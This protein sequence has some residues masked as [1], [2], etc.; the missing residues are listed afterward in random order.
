[1]SRRCGLFGVHLWCCLAFACGVNAATR[2]ALVSTCGGDAA[3][4]V[5]ALAEAKLSIEPGVILV[6]RAQ[7]E[8]ILQEQNLWRCGLG[9]AEQAAAAGKLLGVELFAALETIPGSE[10]ALGLVTF[11]ASSG[12]RLSDAVLPAGGVDN[13]VE[14]IVAGVRAGC[15][16]RRR[17]PAQLRTVC[18]MSVRNAEL[19]R[20]LDSFCDATARLLERRLLG[21]EEVTVLERQRLEQINR[22]RA[23]PTGA[24]PT[25]LLA[26]LRLVEIEFARGP[27]GKGLAATGFL[28]DAAD[29]VLGQVQAQSEGENAVELAEGLAAGIAR[30]LKAAPAVGVMDRAREAERFLREARFLYEHGDRVGHLRALETVAALDPHNAT[31]R[32]LLARALLNSAHGA[33]GTSDEQ[34]R[35]CSEQPRL[36][37]CPL[38]A[39]VASR[40]SRLAD[41]RHPKHQDPAQQHPPAGR[42]GHCGGERCGIEPRDR[43]RSRSQQSQPA[44]LGSAGCS[45]VV[46]EQ[47]TIAEAT[48]LMEHKIRVER[49]LWA[50][51]PQ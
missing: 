10:Q 15:E 35:R 21:S 27:G 8:R 49:E 44:C 17:A 46:S 9:D 7:V 51:A 32:P 26:S 5:L 28:T 12:A 19:P 42:G 25:D 20:A 14:G 33:L 43:N 31:V 39:T 1:M 50:T 37:A 18:V 34:L 38:A 40:D 3:G 22:E 47:L 36:Q 29:S 11:D 45:G 16:K 41:R 48:E 2:V 13:T 6:E 4:N 23:L 30:A 24:P